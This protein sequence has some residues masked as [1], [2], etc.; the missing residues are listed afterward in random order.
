MTRY[1]GIVAFGM[2]TLCGGTAALAQDVLGSYAAYIGQQ[3]LYNSNGARLSAPWQ[4]LRQDRANFHRFGI[5]QTGDEW[6]PFFGD[7]NNREA[8]ERMVMQGYMDPI[9]ARDIMA[10]GATVVVTIYGTGKSG[11]YVN[12]DVYR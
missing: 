2:M 12:V 11:Q 1:L 7:A 9:A 10:G 6:D 5:S 4:V 8:M 3:D